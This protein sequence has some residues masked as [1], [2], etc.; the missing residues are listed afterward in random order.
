MSRT[1]LLY[2]LF[3]VFL[4]LNA[5]QN[6]PPPTNPPPTPSST[7]TPSVTH[8][9]LPTET[10]TQ[11]P[12][13]SPTPTPTLSLPVGANTPVPLS[14][15]LIVRGNIAN[16]R[17]LAR[18]V[19]SIAYRARITSDNNL[20]FIRNRLGLD[21]YDY[22]S[23][24]KLAHVDLY[25][26][27][28]DRIDL[29]ISTDGKTVLLD[30]RWLLEYRSDGNFS[31]IKD[32]RAELDLHFPGN[33]YIVLSPDG[34]QLAISERSCPNT[35]IQYFY[36]YNLIEDQYTYNW[37]GGYT[38]MH[39]YNPV[40]SPD[41]TFVATEVDYSVVI[42]DSTDGTKITQFAYP[43]ARPSKGFAFLGQPSLFSIRYG[44]HL[45]IWDL[46]TKEK[47]HDI[48][49][50]CGS[51]PPIHLERPK[52]LVIPMCENYIGLWSIKEANWM[53]MEQYDV[54]ASSILF[55]DFGRAIVL[56]DPARNAAWPEF[57][58][59]D[60]FKFVSSGSQEMEL[61]QTGGGETCMI[62]LDGDD[63]ACGEDLIPGTDGLMYG[64]I[65]EEGF[66]EIFSGESNRDQIISRL[67]WPTTFGY[68]LALDPVHRLAFFYDKIVDLDSGSAIEQW[69][70]RGIRHLSTSPNNSYASLCL[71]SE[72]NHK[73]SIHRLA[74]FDLLQKRII[75]QEYLPCYTQGMAF[76]TDESE[77][78]FTEF[79]PL[80]DGSEIRN[81]YIH[82]LNLND[83][84][85]RRSIT[86]DC[87]VN[88]LSYSHD[89]S[90]IA[91]G[92]SDGDIRFYE[93]VQLTEVHRISEYP[94]I[95]GLTF[96]P[97][98]KMLGVAY[99]RGVTSIFSIQD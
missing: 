7:V 68:I 3:L 99:G 81:T 11:T 23:N 65:I 41:S 16:L 19:G 63:I 53:T 34:T 86:A 60:Y 58:S 28:S 90:L 37:A 50:V 25:T 75:L 18:Y 95:L 64:Y 26:S 85:D 51:S 94:N 15:N 70:G 14:E 17:E 80:E 69:S 35:C 44:T 32:L 82:F 47:I 98:G 66:L 61:W 78:A 5:C 92:C 72:G 84:H 59:L 24:T 39:G 8:T 10:P 29:Q 13:Q 87:S 12:T 76:S 6:N 89:D 30:R 97:D 9:P 54:D 93:T 2:S 71:F 21:V 31:D 36:I 83:L 57:Y 55:E 88:A 20:L 49:G 74:I 43:Y 73:R 52:Y 96:S 77:L 33:A 4:L 45:E 67:R 91:A 56:P 38:E 1:N 27:R 79:V 22:Q 40:F 62:P 46:G 42:W 48:N